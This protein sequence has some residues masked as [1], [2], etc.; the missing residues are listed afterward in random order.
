MVGGLEWLD[1]R[2]DVMQW[3]ENLWFNF[4]TPPQF[5]TSKVFEVK[6]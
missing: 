2:H 4:T 3:E 6:F 1:M 5:S